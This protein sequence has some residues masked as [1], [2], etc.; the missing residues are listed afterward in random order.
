MPGSC[1]LQSQATTAAW[2]TEEVLV[3]G[4]IQRITN[5][6]TGTE[7]GEQQSLPSEN[8]KETSEILCVCVYVYN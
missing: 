7:P 8:S 4:M 2:S 1:I 3:H 6:V 5:P